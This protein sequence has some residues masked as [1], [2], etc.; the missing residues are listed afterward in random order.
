MAEFAYNHAKNTSIGYTLFELNC[1]FHPRVC[2]KKYVDP[3]SK[4]KTAEQ[5][6][7]ELQTF[8]SAYSE[9]LQHAQEL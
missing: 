8:M 2:Y 4:A 3:H 6:A 1:G 7:T 5:L 9:N